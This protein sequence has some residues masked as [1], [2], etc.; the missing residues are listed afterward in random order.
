MTHDVVVAGTG[1][2]AL[3]A[4]FAA[5]EAGASVLVLEKAPESQRGGFEANPEWRTRYLGPN[6]DLA[7]VRGTR[8][9]RGEGI[10]MAL[11]IGAQAYEDWSSCHAVQWDL[12]APAFGDRKV[13]DMF[14]N[15]S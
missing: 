9:N 13:G 10:R 12:N 15:Q 8:H 3:C 1:N 14:Q 6:W 4:A 2:A 7:C 11:D 5:R